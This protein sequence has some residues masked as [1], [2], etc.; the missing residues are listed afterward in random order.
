MDLYETEPQ[1]LKTNKGK[2]SDKNFANLNT[3]GYI[4]I[5]I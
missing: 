3:V 2:L 1:T 5:L 4:T